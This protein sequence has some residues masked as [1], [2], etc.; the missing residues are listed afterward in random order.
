MNVLRYPIL[1]A[2]LVVGALLVLYGLLGLSYTGENGSGET[3]VKLAGHEPDAHLVGA[4]SL[5][6][7]ALVI[8]CGVLLSPGR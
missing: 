4:V 5:A 8:A 1:V 6:L 2:S 3:Y 7:G